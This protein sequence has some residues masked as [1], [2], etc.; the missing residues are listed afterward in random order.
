[1]RR[2]K[3]TLRGSTL[4]ETLVMMLVAGIVFLA[5]MEA[6]TLVSQLVAR[7]TSGLVEAGRQRDGIFR[8]GQLLTTA[9]SIRGAEGGVDAGERMY[10][11]RAG[12][13]AALTT[14]DSAAVFVAGEF[15]DTLLSRV[16]HMRLL[17]CDAAADTLEIDVEGRTLKLPVPR[18]AR[19][20]YERRIAEIENGYGYEDD[21]P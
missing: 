6:L 12:R 10:F 1:M 7:R 20:S 9:D 4:A 14:R 21:H 19:E 5:A 3:H 15:R 8:L 2:V 18:P 11:Y 16:G 13:E 17:C